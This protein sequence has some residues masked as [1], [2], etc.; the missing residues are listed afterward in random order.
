M[1]VDNCKSSFCWVFPWSDRFH[2]PSKIR[3]IW[4]SQMPQ[5]HDDSFFIDPITILIRIKTNNNNNRNNNVVLVLMSLLPVLEVDHGGSV[6][7][8]VVAGHTSMWGGRNLWPRFTTCHL[9]LVSEC[10]QD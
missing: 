5:R 2:S 3:S 7:M 8:I 6:N 1:L 4:T 10:T 9:P